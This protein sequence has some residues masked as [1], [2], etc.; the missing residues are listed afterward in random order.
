VSY[1]VGIGFNKTGTTSISALTRRLGYPTIHFGGHEVQARITA[2]IAAGSLPLS[3]TPRSWQRAEAIFDVEPI[4]ARFDAFDEAYPGSRFILHTR[5]LDGWLA[6]RA[7]H[8]ERNIELAASGGYHGNFLTVDPAAWRRE[9]S[10][11]HAR[12]REHFRGRP[13]ALLECDFLTEGAEPLLE[14]LDIP[15]SRRLV[16]PESNVARTLDHRRRLAVARRVAI[17]GRRILRR[18]GWLRT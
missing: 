10:E 7:K 18:R 13:E 15:R 8:V 16:L 9:W 14:F 2:A 5:D 6:S 4:R 11:H 12:V 3:D 17:R 1:I